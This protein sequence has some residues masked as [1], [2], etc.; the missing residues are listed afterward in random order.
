VFG[1]DF[2][3]LSF[4]CLSQTIIVQIV[5]WTVLQ[6]QKLIFVNAHLLCSVLIV[7]LEKASLPFDWYSLQLPTEGWPG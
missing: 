3:I 6:L 4:G 5:V 7:F 1:S 2:S